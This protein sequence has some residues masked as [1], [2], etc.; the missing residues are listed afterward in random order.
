VLLYIFRRITTLCYS[1]DNAGMN[2]VYM[3]LIKWISSVMFF[4]VK[5]IAIFVL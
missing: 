2:Y 5:S 1:V 4:T 3:Y